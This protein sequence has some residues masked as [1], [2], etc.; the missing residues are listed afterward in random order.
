MTTTNTTTTNTTTTNTT[1]TNTTN[2]TTNTT[3]TTNTTSV[4][5]FVTPA[6]L[7]K[8]LHADM[9]E[10]AKAF[11]HLDDNTVTAAAK[12]A[13]AESMNKATA[14]YNEAVKCAAYDLAIASDSPIGYICRA[15][16]YTALHPN[17]D[18]K[19]GAVGTRA[20][21]TR[22]DLLDFLKY[23][24]EKKVEGIQTDNLTSSL[25]NL[26]AHMRLL[27]DHTSNH[28]YD[29]HA[30]KALIS[31]ARNCLYK[32]VM[33]LSGI[34]GLRAR[35]NDVVALAYCITRAKELNQ[36]ADITAATVCPFIMD[37]FNA[38]LAGVKW[39]VEVKTANK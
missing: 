26:A 19:S 25:K 4:I 8:D 24:T 2:T 1:N 31:A 21:S 38:Q 27:V 28:G 13:A 12:A 34:E 18:R 3:N 37:M 33:S 16:K 35:D 20:L 7:L 39:S 30:K 11:F 23:A 9:M 10:K 6:D 29:A 32:E 14:A 5:N 15:R 17:K 22:F 36:F